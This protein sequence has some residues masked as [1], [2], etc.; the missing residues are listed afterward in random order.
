MIKRELKKPT[1]RSVMES[2]HNTGPSREKPS[3]EWNVSDGSTRY[4]AK[5]KHKNRPY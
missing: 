2:T 4:V 5:M 1:P 3:F